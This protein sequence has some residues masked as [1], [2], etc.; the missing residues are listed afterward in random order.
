LQQVVWNLL[1][2]A[3]KFTPSGGRVEV[4]LE[5]QGLYAQIRVSDT[6]CGIKPDF[7]PIYF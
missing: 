1:S 2:N 6:G 4:K 3:F 7:L 5:R